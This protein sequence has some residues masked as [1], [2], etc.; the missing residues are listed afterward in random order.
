MYFNG[1]IAGVSA[2]LPQSGGFEGRRDPWMTVRTAH[3]GVEANEQS[4]RRCA[5]AA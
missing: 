1:E 2:L 4:S 5:A 3:C